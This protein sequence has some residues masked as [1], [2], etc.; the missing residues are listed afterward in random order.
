MTSAAATLLTGADAFL[1]AIERMMQKAGQGRHL[2]VT[3]LRLGAGFDAAAFRSAASRLADATPIASARLVHPLLRIPRWEWPRDS[4]AALPV[5]EHPSGTKLEELCE[6]LLNETPDAR[7]SFDFIGAADHTTLVVCWSH[8]MLDGKGVELLLAEIGRLAAEPGSHPRAESWGVAGERKL[9]WR[10]LL[11]EAERFKDGFY[12][13]ARFAIR[14]LGDA[15]PR[16]GRARFI[17]EEFS[18]AETTRIRNRAEM[19]SRGMFQLA[20]FLAASIR[21]HRAV[22]IQRGNEPDSYQAGCAV[23]Q[24]KRGAR[25]PIWQNQVSQFFFRLLPEEAVDL[26][27]AARVLQKQF[28]RHVRERMD[29]AFAT[30]TGLLRRLPASWYLRF[31]RRNSNG[32]ITSFF[33]S[34]TG[35]FLPECECLAGARILNGWHVPSVCAPPGTGLFFSERNG[36]LTATFAWR[37]GAVTPEEIALLRATLREDLLGR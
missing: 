12:E 17:V 2:G 8:L 1:L 20:W 4:R 28:D 29:L 9:H 13:N 6:R 21:A 11:G 30:M 18:H 37:E 23:Q 16:P 35:A 14:S 32:F 26:V 31:L 15:E 33:Y 7:V 25:H 34:H 27:N 5:R 22:F 10:E 36:A 24:R 3:V 19:V